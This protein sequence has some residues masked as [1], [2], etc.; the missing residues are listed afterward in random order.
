MR[1]LHVS[2]LL[3]ASVSHCS[4]MSEAAVAGTAARKNE[5]DHHHYDNTATAWKPELHAWVRANEFM[6]TK[7]LNCGTVGTFGCPHSCSMM[8]WAAKSP[9]PEQD[10]FSTATICCSR[11]FAW[12][13]PLQKTLRE[14]S[15]Y[16]LHRQLA[17]QLARQ[18]DAGLE[19]GL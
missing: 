19:N 18:F 10:W 13:A 14:K 9:G 7:Q 11:R 2:E 5:K 8:S 15:T 4:N 16:H 1:S 12:R 6:T 17:R 3:I